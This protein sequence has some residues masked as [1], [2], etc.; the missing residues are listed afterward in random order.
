MKQNLFLLL[1]IL[2]ALRSSSQVYA[3]TDDGKRVILRGDS[4]WQY[5]AAKETLKEDTMSVKTYK[6]PVSARTLRP[7]ERNKFGLWLDEKKW[8]SSEQL[9]TLAE[10]SFVNEGKFAEAYCLAITERVSISLEMLKKQVIANSKGAIENYQLIKE[11]YLTVNGH[12]VLHMVFKGTVQNMAAEYSGY[13]ATDA[14]GV[15]QLLCF[16]SENL[17]SSYEKDFTDLLNGLVVL[18]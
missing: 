18:P 15:I 3:T 13:Y 8:K 1:L 4:T 6:K 10:L 7:S 12:K 16:T 2:S 9:N 11:E 5:V 14:S 17:Y